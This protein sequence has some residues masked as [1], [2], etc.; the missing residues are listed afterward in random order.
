MSTFTVIAIPFIVTGVIM[1]VLAAT[2]KQRAFLI[3]GGM[4]IASSVVNAVI[5][6][7]VG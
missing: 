4:F 1:L 5:G 3:M 6:M 7:S 2:M